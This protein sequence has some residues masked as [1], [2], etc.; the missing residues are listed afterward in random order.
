MTTQ[1]RRPHRLVDEEAGAVASIVHDT[2]TSFRGSDFDEAS[3]SEP[4]VSSEIQQKTKS[5]VEM[6]EY[7]DMFRSIVDDRSHS[8]PTGVQK[9]TSDRYVYAREI[10]SWEDEGGNA[11]SR[12][13][14]PR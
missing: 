14:P 5:F 3:V 11:D 6:K 13:Q 7:L 1:Q 12:V 2:I 4:S 8:E 9:K 10:A